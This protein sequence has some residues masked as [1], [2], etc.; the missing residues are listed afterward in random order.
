MGVRGV[1]LE[2]PDR[3]VSE[4]F[5]DIQKA[6]PQILYVVLPHPDLV[7]VNCTI[8]SERTLPS[9]LRVAA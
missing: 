3:E 8:K 5:S 1:R 7:V 9:A 4:L 2:Q 6:S